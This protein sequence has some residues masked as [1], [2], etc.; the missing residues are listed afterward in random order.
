MRATF[1]LGVLKRFEHAENLGTSGGTDEPVAEIVPNTQPQLSN[2]FGRQRLA[3][4]VAIRA[5]S[6]VIEFT[7]TNAQARR[8]G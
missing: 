2:L 6:D 8:V 5:D 1:L 3:V 4:Q 7:P